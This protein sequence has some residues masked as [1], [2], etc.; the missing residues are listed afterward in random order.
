[1]DPAGPVAKSPYDLALLLDHMAPNQSNNCSVHLP[2]D[3]Y[4][5]TETYASAC[6]LHM[7]SF[8]GPNVRTTSR[9]ACGRPTTIHLGARA[10]HAKASGNVSS[11]NDGYIGMLVAYGFIARP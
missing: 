2:N 9:A 10:I 1:M 5:P 4:H 7:V 11:R 3:I 6:L 8:Q